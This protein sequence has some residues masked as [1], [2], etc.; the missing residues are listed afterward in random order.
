MPNIK[1][2][3]GTY[4][5]IAHPINSETRKMLEEKILAH[6]EELLRNLTASHTPYTSK[7]LNDSETSK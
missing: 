7:H 4:K 1:L 2:K 3:N 6:Y 5:D